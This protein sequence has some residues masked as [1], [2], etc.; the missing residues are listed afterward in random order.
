[1]KRI[2]LSLAFLI[3]N[4]GADT[5]YNTLPL[6]FHNRRSY[7]GLVQGAD[8]LWQGLPQDASNKTASCP[9]FYNLIGN[10]SFSL[11]GSPYVSECEFMESHSDQLHG[12]DFVWVDVQWLFNAFFT[13][14][15]LVRLRD[16]REILLKSE[17]FNALRTKMSIERL[18]QLLPSYGGV[19]MVDV[20]C[21]KS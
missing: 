17:L 20:C 5:L 6:S 11:V 7:I 2:L 16:G 10:Y 19:C 14:R 13:N 4:I 1:M 3:F 15:Q 12:Q 21:R 8:G 9:Q 18:Q